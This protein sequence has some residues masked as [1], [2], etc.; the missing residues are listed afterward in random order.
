[1][2]EDTLGA[3]INRGHSS[4][5][6]EGRCCKRREGKDIEGIVDKDEDIK[7]MPTEGLGNKRG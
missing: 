6:R 5:N 4:S 2:K 7:S 3:R 1:M